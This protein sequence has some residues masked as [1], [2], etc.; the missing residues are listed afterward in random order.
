ME[1]SDTKFA[2]LNSELVIKADL[3]GFPIR[4]YVVTLDLSETKVE[5]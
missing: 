1:N 5:L 4:K 3:A 2:I